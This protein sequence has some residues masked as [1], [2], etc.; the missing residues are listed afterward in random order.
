LWVEWKKHGTGAES[1]RK[2]G[3]RSREVLAYGEEAEVG[4][5]TKR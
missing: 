4:M 3:G 1:D 5:K 2:T